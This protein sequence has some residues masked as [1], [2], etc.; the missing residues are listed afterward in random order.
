MTT[1]R[2]VLAGAAAPPSDF[3]SRA[4]DGFKTAVGASDTGLKV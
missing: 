1:R 4:L 2:L 3:L